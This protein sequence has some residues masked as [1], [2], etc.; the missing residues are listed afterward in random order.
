MVE[1]GKPSLS[2]L[3]LVKT[4]F[5]EDYLL[6]SAVVDGREVSYISS[7]E[8]AATRAQRAVWVYVA[9]IWT[10]FFVNLFILNKNRKPNAP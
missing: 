1:S 9:L 8:N 10:A 6:L 3:K 5:L 2:H 7:V 4:S